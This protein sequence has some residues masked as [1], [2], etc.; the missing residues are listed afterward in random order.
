MPDY[1]YRI[2]NKDNEIQTGVLTAADRPAATAQ[3][4]KRG[5]VPLELSSGG[6]SLAMRLNEPVNLFGKPNQRDVHAFMR[7]LAR[8][9]RAGLSMDDALKLLKT[10]HDKELFVRLLDDLR[11]RVRRG[12]GL[13]AAMSE[14]KQLFSVQEIASVHAG[15]LSGKLAD[16]LDTI[17][18]SMDKSLS[19]QERLRGALIYPSILMVMVCA[20]FVLV[21]T[22]VLPQF[23]PVFEGN[24]D[25]LPVITRF[26]MALADFFSE[27]LWLVTT[28]LVGALVWLVV[29]LH[30]PALKM[31]VL[32]KICAL[33]LAQ[34]W[35]VTPDLIRVVRTLGVCTKSGLALDKSIAMSMEAVRIPHLGEDLARVRAMVRRGELLSVSLARLGW[36]SPVTLQFAR[37]GEQS[38]KLGAMLDESAT[39]VAQEFEE[40]LERGLAILSPFLTLVMGGMVAL[41]VGSVLLG[42]MSIND[43][44]L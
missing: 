39:I 18:A 29:V 21:M 33:P 6:K 43:V 14:H 1:H 42:I 27:Y 24:E 40:R 22:F 11:E 13:A 30:T 17:A 34:R 20:T 32:K 25:K 19:F 41:L 44:A 5:W 35:I 3:L 36:I 8:L 4:H 26:V 31:A 10:T 37:V 2:L 7:D 23:A 28:L 12:E 38:G 9:L 16:A 15:E